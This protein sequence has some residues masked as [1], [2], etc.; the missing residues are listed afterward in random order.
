MGI[1]WEPGTPF[2]EPLYLVRYEDKPEEPEIVPMRS[3]LDLIK[4]RVQEGYVYA[5]WLA[6]GPKNP[7]R[8]GVTDATFNTPHFQGPAGGQYYGEQWVRS[9]G[10]DPLRRVR[11]AFGPTY[12][13][14]LYAE[15]LE[16]DDLV[17]QILLMERGISDV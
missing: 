1:R 2:P 13:R 14:L 4:R 10:T 3:I 16:A 5:A 15:P 8:G 6:G 12:S 11:E 9:N 7:L 17:H